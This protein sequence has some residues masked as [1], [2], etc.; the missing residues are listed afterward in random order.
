MTDLILAQVQQAFAQRARPDRENGTD[1]RE[2]TVDERAVLDEA[3]SLVWQEIPAD[4]WEKNAEVTSWFSPTAYCYYLPGIITTTLAGNNPNLA[5]AC[6]VL[7]MLDRT[8]DKTL[9]DN[10]FYSRWHLF[11]G[12]ELVAIASWLE[13]LA[14]G[15]ASVLDDIS[16]TRA[17]LTIELLREELHG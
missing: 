3:L 5:A 14:A 11:N 9:W 1:S 12:Q 13:W 16:L 17:L 7:F 2:L 10:F 15:K 6:S 8:P 4:W